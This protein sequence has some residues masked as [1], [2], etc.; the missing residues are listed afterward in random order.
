MRFLPEMTLLLV[1]HRPVLL[2]KLRQRGALPVSIEGVNI[3]SNG[4]C[5][6][7]TI[8]KDDMI[9]FQLLEPKGEAAVSCIVYHKNNDVAKRLVDL[10][11]ASVAPFNHSFQSDPSYS[12]Y[13]KELLKLESKAERKKVGMWWDDKA[14][15]SLTSTI[16]RKLKQALPS[17]RTVPLLR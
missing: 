16:L 14:Y 6:L 4:V 13:Y 10:G 3:T 15:N 9:D 12:Q 8:V 5:W 2:A 7:Q 17:V 1:D 11:F